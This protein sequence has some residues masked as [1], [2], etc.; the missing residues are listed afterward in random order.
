M[1]SAGTQ[2]ASALRRL[3]ANRLT[4]VSGIIREQPSP[5]RHIN[6]VGAMVCTQMPSGESSSARAPGMP[7]IAALLVP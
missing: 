4:L 2:R 6:D 5:H 7:S 1:D 3:A